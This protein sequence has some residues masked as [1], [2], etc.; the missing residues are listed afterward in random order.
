MIYGTVL[1][2][3]AFDYIR[4]IHTTYEFEKI[5]YIRANPHNIWIREN[6]V[7]MPQS[8]CTIAGPFRMNKDSD[9]NKEV[10]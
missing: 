6:P 5:D 10:F 4:A 7:N 3:T 9:K 8:A 2:I 1:Y